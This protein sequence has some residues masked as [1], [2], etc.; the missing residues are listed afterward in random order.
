[1]LSWKWRCS[2]SSA[3]R[4]CS[5]Y[6][7]VINYFI[8]YKGATYMRGFTVVCSL[9]KSQLHYKTSLPQ[10]TLISPQPSQIFDSIWDYVSIC[11]DLLTPYGQEPISLRICLLAILI[12]RKHP[13][14]V[15]HLLAIKSLQ[16]FARATVVSGAKAL[17]RPIRWKRYDSRTK[18]PWIWIAMAKPLVK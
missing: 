13:L 7:Y 16:I 10:M 9:K 2:W 1:M 4:W 12:R 6:I 18:L 8:A 14:A 11:I 17:L 15:I 5:N 3:D